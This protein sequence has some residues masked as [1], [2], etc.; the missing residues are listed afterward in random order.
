MSTELADLFRTIIQAQFNNEKLLYSLA[1]IA[2]YSVLSYFVL[3]RKDIV[4]DNAIGNTKTTIGVYLLNIAFAPVVFVCI[5]FMEE[6]CRFIGLVP[7]FPEFWK[8]VHPVLLV[9]LIIV[10][11]DF[12]DYWN[13]RFMHTKWGWPIHAIHHSDSHV[14]GFTSFRVHFLEAVVMRG[15]YLVFLGWLG[16]PMEAAATAY[17]FLLLHNIYVHLEVD[18]DHG[19]LNYLIT[20][21]RFHRWHHADV[22]EAYGK[23]LANV[24]PLFDVLFGTYRVPGPCNEK[25]GALADNIP[26]KDAV[27]L[28]LLP[29]V[30]WYRLLKRQP[31]ADAPAHMTPAE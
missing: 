4:S 12:M 6:I 14:N 9:L 17:V 30:L 29:F 5:L 18:I 7:L 10:A 23:N 19:P 1:F 31:A 20:S 25:M 8:S 28:I 21:P 27:K 13:H 16:L 22:K 3:R 26:D 11:R 24:I 15:S 2:V